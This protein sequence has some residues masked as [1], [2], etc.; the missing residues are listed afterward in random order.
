MNEPR[1]ATEVL[2]AYLGGAGGQYTPGIARIG[3]REY[4]CEDIPMGQVTK[5]GMEL[6]AL[7]NWN[8]N[9]RVAEMI[10]RGAPRVLDAVRMVNNYTHQGFGGAAA[11]GQELV[12]NPMTTSDIL[13]YSP[14]STAIASHSKYTAENWTMA[15]AA[16]GST[17]WS[18]TSTYNNPMLVSSLPHVAHVYL[19]FIDPVEVPKIDMIQFIKDGTTICREYLALNW[20]EQFGSNTVPMHELKQPW[21]A[22]PQCNYYIAAHY[23]ITGDDKLQ[24]IAFVVQK[25]DQILSALA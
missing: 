11:K 25:A 21:I 15:I 4:A 14:G 16:V 13:E 22:H 24:P 17:A 19:G 1:S 2:K 12:V 23:F 9:P 3:G 7:L 18:G 6:D 5:L 20:R 10:I 8:D